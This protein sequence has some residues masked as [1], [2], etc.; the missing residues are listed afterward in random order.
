MLHLA[1]K[2]DIWSQANEMIYDKDKNEWGKKVQA[3]EFKVAMVC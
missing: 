1:D 3:T 2:V